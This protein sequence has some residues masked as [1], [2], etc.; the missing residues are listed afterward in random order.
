MASLLGF[1]PTDLAGLA[2]LRDLGPSGLSMLTDELSKASVLLKP[3]ELEPFFARHVSSHAQAAAD[4]MIKVAFAARAH[5][6]SIET[7]VSD[8]AETIR[9]RATPPWSPEELARWNEISEQVC[10][11]AGHE[12]LRVL[13]KAVDLKYAHSNIYQR[14]QLITDV[15]PVFDGAHDRPV[16]AVIS[17][18]LQVVYQ[19]DGQRETLTLA[20][21]DLDV[22]QLIEQANGAKRKAERLLT[23]FEDK[24][25]SEMRFEIVGKEGDVDEQ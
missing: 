10:S 17:H 11:L 20:L 9:V 3:T 5:G 16:A 2:V 18:T 25:G 4:V 24:L 19:R 22:D 21:D 15:R 14:A 8:V 13:S 23:Y 6:K 12:R 1:S 7:V